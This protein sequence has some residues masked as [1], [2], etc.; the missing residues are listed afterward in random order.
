[1]LKI[2]FGAAGGKTCSGNELVG[3]AWPRARSEG[4][5]E[6]RDACDGGW[7]PAVLWPAVL[8]WQGDHGQ[9]PQC[10]RTPASLLV[11]GFGEWLPR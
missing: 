4:D 5:G 10:P 8:S 6:A 2:A 1:M 3:L 9:M 11:G 7:A